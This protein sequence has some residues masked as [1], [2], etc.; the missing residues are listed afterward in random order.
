M[1]AGDQFSL[2]LRVQAQQAVMSLPLLVGFDP[3]LMQVVSVAEGDF[4]RQGGAQTN[5]TSRIDP[6]TGQIFIGAM[7]QGGGTDGAGTLMNLTFKALKATP[8]ASIQILTATPDPQPQG[9]P[10]ALPV[11]HALAIGK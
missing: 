9:G 7:R 4:L 8:Q 3:T 5:F 1:K 2:A 6:Q 10:I 11:G